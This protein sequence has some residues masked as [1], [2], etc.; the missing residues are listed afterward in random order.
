MERISECNLCNFNTITVL[1]NDYKKKHIFNL[2][3][4][5]DDDDIDI[6]DIV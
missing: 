1:F 5:D 2:D 6:C 4:F 3:C